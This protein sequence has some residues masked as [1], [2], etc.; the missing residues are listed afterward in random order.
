MIEIVNQI[1]IETGSVNPTVDRTVMINEADLVIIKI[2]IGRGNAVG[3]TTKVDDIE[4]TAINL[5]I[6]INTGMIKVP[7]ILIMNCE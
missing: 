3:K 7:K 6:E 5:E 2:V 1:V 4:M